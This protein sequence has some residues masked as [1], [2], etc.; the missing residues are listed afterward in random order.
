MVGLKSVTLALLFSTSCAAAA[1]EASSIARLLTEADGDSSNWQ[2]SFEILPCQLVMHKVA[3]PQRATQFYDLMHW[4]FPNAKLKTTAMGNV[5][6]DI[7]WIEPSRTEF[8]EEREVNAVYVV[9]LVEKAFAGLQGNED[10]RTLVRLRDQVSAQAFFEGVD[11]AYGPHSRSNF[12]RTRFVYPDD[13]AKIHTGHV[14]YPPYRFPFLPNMADEAI[15]A[16]RNW[17]KNS[18]HRSV[19]TKH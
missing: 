16:L 9:E 6:L 10:K 14:I 12:E 3:G 2:I 4:D 5:I 19:S 7:D 8:L 13:G 18:C 1:D 11:G 17:Q 15:D